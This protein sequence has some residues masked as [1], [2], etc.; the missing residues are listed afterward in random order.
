[1]CGTLTDSIQTNGVS[2]MED[3]KE[4]RQIE[5][6]P[7][8]QELTSR[9]DFL[10]SLKKW[11]QAVIGGVVLGSLVPSSEASAWVNRRGSWVNGGGGYRYRGG[12][13]RYRG[14]GWLN[15]GGGWLNGGG[16]WI[17]SGYNWIN[18]GGTWI[19]GGSGW[20]NRGGGGWV[21]YRGG[22]GGWINRRGW[23]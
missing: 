15:R 8:E 16:G 6:A 13:Y 9:R 5:D 7:D 22:G 4:A 20:I 11:S 14:G 18:R 12:G 1:V 19:N 21:N 10:L 17:N 2:V 23:Y 3:D